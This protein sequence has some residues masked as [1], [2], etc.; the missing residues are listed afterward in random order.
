M[1]LRKYRTSTPLHPRLP[2][3][4]R[5]RK[6][7]HGLRARGG[8]GDTRPFDARTG[9]GRVAEV[10]GDYHRAETVSGLRVDALLFV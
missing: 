7:V 6:C 5:A 3:R 4:P 2:K 1:V 10:K 9:L 8:G